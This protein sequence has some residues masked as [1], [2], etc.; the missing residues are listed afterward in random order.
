MTTGSRQSVALSPQKGGRDGGLSDGAGVA[1]PAG[2]APRA[3][4]PAR[5]LIEFL[6]TFCSVQLAAGAQ[7]SRVDRNT[8]RIAKAYG[9]DVELAMLSRHF[10]ISVVKPAPSGIPQERRT[11]VCAIVSGA[12]NFQRVAALNAL[13]WHIGDEG[14]DL[15]EARR[16]FDAILAVPVLNP[17]LLRFLVAC[18]NAAF[19]RLFDGDA[20]AMGLVFCATLAAFYLRQKL[21]HWGMD[22]KITFFCSAFTASMLAS[23]GLIF[24]WG[25]TPQTAIAASVLFLIPGIPLINAMM[26]ILDGHVLMA[27]SR[28]VQASTLIVCIA[29]GLALTMLLL[30]VDS[31]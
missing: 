25:T 17:V 4:P 11:A 23:P 13:S 9:F 6:Q 3:A 12:P 20:I 24:G 22:M 18:A 27:V 15:D 16:R 10:T 28:L 5:E 26:D 2:S 19:C 21:L 30:G 1:L 29:L 14:L 8:A 7:T 31:L